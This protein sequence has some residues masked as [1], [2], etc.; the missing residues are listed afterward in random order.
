LS[1]AQPAI[2]PATL[3]IVVIHRATIVIVVALAKLTKLSLLQLLACHLLGL[4]H[5]S[6]L[7][8]LLLEEQLLLYQITA[9]LS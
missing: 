9:S 2:R 1:L 8:G 6:S 7:P 3:L 5:A 4:L